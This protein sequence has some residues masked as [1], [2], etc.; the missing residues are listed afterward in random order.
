MTRGRTLVATRVVD[1]AHLPP[2]RHAAAL[3]AFIAA[4]GRA[5]P[6]RRDAG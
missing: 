1:G 6:V 4:L 2:P 3:D 5:P